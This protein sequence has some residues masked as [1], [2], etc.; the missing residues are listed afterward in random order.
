MG[1]RSGVCFLSSLFSFSDIKINILFPMM[2]YVPSHIVKC[3]FFLPINAMYFVV[4]YLRCSTETCNETVR[5]YL[6]PRFTY[7]DL[8]IICSARS[9]IQAA[10]AP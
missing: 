6:P 10:V 5:W 4:R 1:G 3:A 2:I 7:P 8:I 9:S